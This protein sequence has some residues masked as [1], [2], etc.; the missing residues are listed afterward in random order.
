MKRKG[1]LSLRMWNCEGRG[2]EGGE[3]TLH[4]VDI[5]A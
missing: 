5:A 2:G 4:V 3:G 1:R